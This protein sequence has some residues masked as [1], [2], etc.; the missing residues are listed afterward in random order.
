MNLTKLT[1]IL[2]EL[3]VESKEVKDLQMAHNRY[4]RS[5]V[6]NRPAMSRI[7]NFMEDFR[8]EHGNELADT[9][10]AHGAIM[11]LTR[12]NA[13]VSGKVKERIANSKEVQAYIVAFQ[14]APEKP[15]YDELAVENE[16]FDL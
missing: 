13:K 9:A 10:I 6:D 8:D 11:H 2:V 4:I 16:M 5:A 14:S 15:E 7:N 1:K 12:A 3:G